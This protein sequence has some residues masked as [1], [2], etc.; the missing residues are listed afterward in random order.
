MGGGNS[1]AN[2]K[3]VNTDYNTINTNQ[4]QFDSKLNNVKGEINSINQL[5]TELK[6]NGAAGSG[7]TKKTI[8][9]G[10]GGGRYDMNGDLNNIQNLINQY[11]SNIS[12]LQQRQASL[13]QKEKDLLKLSTGPDNSAEFE[14]KIQTI[15]SDF[16]NQ[17]NLLQKNI[18]ELKGQLQKQID[19]YNQLNSEY[20][21][22]VDLFNELNTKYNEEIDT[23]V[24]LQQNLFY[25][26]H[27]PI[28]NYDEMYENVKKQ[29]DILKTQIGEKADD[30]NIDDQLVFYQN[31]KVQ[32]LKNINF[33]LFWI[34]HF[35]VL[36][37]LI[38][39]FYF[40]K[41]FSLKVKILVIFLF[42]LYPYLIGYSEKM[43]YFICTYFYNIII[44]EAYTKVERYNPM[45]SY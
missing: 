14:A 18:F 26:Q 2:S 40:N 16:T 13:V 23:N 25:L 21:T 33:Y 32:V 12:S 29:N 42:I 4:D 3:Y 34:Y 39:L 30:L 24:K 19:N 15:R 27:H 36:I 11:T 22:E 1:K 43:I 31:Q 17:I 41:T 37:A 45:Y 5:L 38:F 7:G 35:L 6:T 9:G 8:R 10:G 28:Q 20:N 44:G